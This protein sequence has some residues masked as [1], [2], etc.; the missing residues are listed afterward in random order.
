MRILGSSGLCP[1]ELMAVP[2]PGYDDSFVQ[3]RWR[4]TG[5]RR[6]PTS[7]K[8]PRWGD[9]SVSWG[10]TQPRFRRPFPRSP[11]T[12]SWLLRGGAHLK[13]LEQHRKENQ[14]EPREGREETNSRRM[15]LHSPARAMAA[16]PTRSRTMPSPP[17]ASV[18]RIAI[19]LDSGNPAA[20]DD[21]SLGSEPGRTWQPS[22]LRDGERT[23]PYAQTEAESGSGIGVG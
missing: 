13:D 7:G 23:W 2:E 12:R 3:N 20:G 1:H 6:H 5:R 22:T 16:P 15:P 11:L 9:R 21:E 14:G 19:P 4:S 10:P 8:T 18:K 17:R